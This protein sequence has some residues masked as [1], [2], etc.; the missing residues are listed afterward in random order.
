[1]RGISINGTEGAMRQL[2][3]R[4]VVIDAVSCG[5]LIELSGEHLDKHARSVVRI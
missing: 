2:S 3:G 4:P 5:V 1:M